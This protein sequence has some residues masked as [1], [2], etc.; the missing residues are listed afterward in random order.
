MR[1]AARMGSC[2][3]TDKALFCSNPYPILLS[4]IGVHLA[5]RATCRSLMNA[6]FDGFPSA[7][8]TAC[9]QASMIKFSRSAQLYLENQISQAF[10]SPAVTNPTNPS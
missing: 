8:A 5:I 1:L 2:S 7:I 6:S 10:S 3:A 9:S 4:G